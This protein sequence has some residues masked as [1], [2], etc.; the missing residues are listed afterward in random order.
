MVRPNEPMSVR[1]R[2]TAPRMCQPGDGDDDDDYDLDGDD[3][4]DLDGDDG[5]GE[6]HTC[7]LDSQS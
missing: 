2:L 3:E 7:N 6:P 5:D 1:P 4:G